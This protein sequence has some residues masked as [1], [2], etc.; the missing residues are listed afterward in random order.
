MEKFIVTK[1]INVTA[2]FHTTFIINRFHYG[3]HALVVRNTAV[4]C[5]TMLPVWFVIIGKGIKTHQNVGGIERNAFGMVGEKWSIDDD[6]V[7]LRYKW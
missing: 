5:N 4:L 7:R 3:K 1:G 2:F 6:D